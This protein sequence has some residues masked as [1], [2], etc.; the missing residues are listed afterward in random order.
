[1]PKKIL[2]LHSRGKEVIAVQRQLNRYFCPPLVVDGVYGRKT[3]A[4]VRRFQVSAGFRGRDVDGKVGPKTMVALF[5]IFDMEICGLLV[6]KSNVLPAPIN[7]PTR[8]PPAD[9][10]NQLPKPMPLLSD[11]TKANAPDDI[12]RRFQANAQFG[13]QQSQR[14]GSGLQAQLGLTFRSKDYFPNSGANTIYHGIHLETILQPALGIPLPPSS[15]YTGQLGITVQPVT[16]WFVL[17]DRLH[18]LTPTFG[19]FAQIP[20]NPPGG[21]NALS[22]PASHPRLGVNLGVELFHVD[23][24]KDRLA[25]GISG[26]ESGYWDF[27]DRKLF[28]DPSIL[29]FLQGTIGFGPRVK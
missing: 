28:W 18:I 27:S 22:D 17:F 7:P 9:P 2:M 13:V 4:A 1:M 21:P 6:P 11:Q 16:D 25:I 24:I 29:G 23:I 12:P 26:Q 3:E 5:Q 8:K 14:D 10:T 20:L 15:I 19:V